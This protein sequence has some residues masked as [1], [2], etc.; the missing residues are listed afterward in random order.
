MTRISKA[1]DTLEGGKLAIYSLFRNNSCKRGDFGD[2][3]ID[4]WFRGYCCGD[5]LDLN[6]TS[7][8]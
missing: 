4:D 5:N 3:R 2:P 7:R 6:K 8:K 1:G